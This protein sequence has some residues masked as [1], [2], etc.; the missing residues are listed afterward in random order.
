MPLICA[1]FWVSEIA[2]L[3][4]AERLSVA[5]RKQQSMLCRLVLAAYFRRIIR[6]GGAEQGMSEANQQAAAQDASG[7]TMGG[8]SR[9]DQ[10]DNRQQQQ[11]NAWWV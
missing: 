9:D 8:D 1:S 4:A 2:R 3:P 7:G 10:G 11:P 5:R 6:I